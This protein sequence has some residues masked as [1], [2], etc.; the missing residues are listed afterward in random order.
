MLFSNKL[1]LAF[2]KEK[3]T[4]D[5]FREDSIYYMIE[6]IL[7]IKF[8]TKL[9]NDSFFISTSYCFH[10]LSNI[11]KNLNLWKPKTKYNRFA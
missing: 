10:Y 7:K 9:C 11:K 2:N 4:R 8:R 6:S 3:L 5:N 1:L